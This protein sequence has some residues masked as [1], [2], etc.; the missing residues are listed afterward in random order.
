MEKELI[1][2]L[3]AMRYALKDVMDQLPIEERFFNLDYAAECDLN[4][5]ELLLK[6]GV[7]PNNMPA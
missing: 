1:E 2:A 3:I 4:A 7:N 5:Q 6:A